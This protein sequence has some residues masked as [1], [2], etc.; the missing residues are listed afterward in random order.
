MDQRDCIH[1]PTLYTTDVRET[2]MTVEP[3]D[4]RKTWRTLE[5]LHAL[6]YVAPEAEDAYCN[7]GL[8]PG[9]GYFP[10]RAAPLG[11]V[12]AELVIAT[13]F[14]FCP[15]LVRSA[16]SD[17]WGQATP[18]QI[19]AAR[20]SAATAALTRILGD[21]ISQSSEMSDA[22]RLARTAAEAA[23]ALHGRPLFAA[24]TAVPWPDD[25]LSIL[26]HAATLLREYRGDGHVALLAAEGVSPCEALQMNAAT[27]GPQPEH[28][29]RSRGWS[30]SEWSRAGDAL[31]TRGWFDDEHQLTEEG[32][33]R[34]ASV[35]RRTDE[36]ALQP[37]ISIGAQGCGQLR[38][39][40]RPWA[41]LIA[42]SGAFG[43]VS[44]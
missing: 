18:E 31:R 30:V 8:R 27:G 3:L 42:G 36:L 16:M 28:L 26:W 24:H 32:K 1:V 13:F 10:S 21:E 14:N 20:Q 25:T 41:R 6:V 35:E 9:R 5:P 2:E 19:I 11:A 22:A 12:G 33:S 29:R 44:V 17:A 4:A 37:Y 43:A 34:W 15:D 23:V 40:C 39:L 38:A 7:L